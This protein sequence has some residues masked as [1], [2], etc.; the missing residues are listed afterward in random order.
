[1]KYFILLIMIFF[2]TSTLALE[3]HKD[4]ISGSTS[5]LV[6]I[7]SV[8][9][10]NDVP[11]GT[12]VWRSEVLTNNFVCWSTTSK[13]DEYVYI[14]TY[15]EVSGSAAM[16]EGVAFGIIYDGVDLGTNSDKTQTSLYFTKSEKG[17]KYA[18]T[19]TMSYQI[20]IKKTANLSSSIVF[21]TDEIA[22][23]QLDGVGGINNNAG[24]NYRYTLT[25]LTNF[26]AL[27]CSANIP[28][29]TDVDFGELKPWNST[30]SVI[31]RKD[32]SLAV[33]RTCDAPFSLDALFTPTGTVVNNDSVDL[34]NGA[35][36]KIYDPDTG[37]YLV[38]NDLTDFVDLTTSKS[39]T[40]TYQAV[41]VSNGEAKTGEFESDIIFT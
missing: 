31:T 4:S 13:T 27:E 7:G 19:L 9:I 1:M 34:G 23:F 18:K 35:L 28:E 24:L 2:S 30:G 11:D 12:I 29:V 21:D 37:N 33:S 17:S 8:K 38:F 41:L 6:N 26:V 20:Y 40:K 15:P 32:F 5:E 39:Q 22:V 25:G 14:Y 10:P 16:P 3:C 36:L